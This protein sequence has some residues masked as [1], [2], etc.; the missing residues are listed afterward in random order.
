MIPLNLCTVQKTPE[1]NLDYVANKENYV[2]IVMEIRKK[3]LNGLVLFFGPT[4][5]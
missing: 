4:T 5:I 3:G 2:C 1:F